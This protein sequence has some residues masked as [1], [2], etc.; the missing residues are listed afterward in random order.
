MSE[1]KGRAGRLRAVAIG[2]LIAGAAL[3]YAVGVA[4]PASVA[5]VPPGL[6]RVTTYTASTDSGEGDFNFLFAFLIAGPTLVSAAILYGAAEIVA[7]LRRSPRTRSS[8][9]GSR[10]GVVSA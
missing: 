10:D 3:A 5:V 7:G 8:E 4:F 6:T 2:V 9:G 1:S